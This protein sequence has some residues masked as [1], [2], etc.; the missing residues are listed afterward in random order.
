MHTFSYR[1]EEKSY[2]STDRKYTAKQ[3][4]PGST[5]NQTSHNRTTTPANQ[6]AESD[7][8]PNAFSQHST[9]SSSTQEKGPASSGK[10]HSTS[11][12]CQERNIELEAASH[13][14]SKQEKILCIQLDLKPTQYLTQKALL[15]QVSAI[16]EFRLQP[17]LIL[18]IAM[19]LLL[20]SILQEYLNG[21]RKTSIVP[22]S[23]RESKILYYLVTNGWIAA[24]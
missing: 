13:L 11:S 21:N 18:Q 17:F 9:S 3:D 19:Y 6:W 23:E 1:E 16:C 22:Q 24:N 14:L 20:I 5:I 7:S 15:L 10:S 8:N 2:A 12:D 4:L